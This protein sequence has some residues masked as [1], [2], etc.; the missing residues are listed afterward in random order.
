ML[1]GLVPDEA[2]NR[3]IVKSG[4]NLIGKVLFCSK[5]CCGHLICKKAFQ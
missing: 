1:A 2:G 5:E 4:S 3:F